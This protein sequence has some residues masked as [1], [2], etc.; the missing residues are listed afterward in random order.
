LGDEVQRLAVRVLRADEQR[1][2]PRLGTR[3]DRGT[4]E[5]RLEDGSGDFTSAP[6]SSPSL[7]GEAALQLSS[8]SD[9]QHSGDWGGFAH[10]VYSIHVV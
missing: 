10:D 1:L 9:R 3:I 4:R 7:A 6:A 8:Q 5:M 2:S